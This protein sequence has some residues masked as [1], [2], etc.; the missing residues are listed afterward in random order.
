MLF[1]SFV[2]EDKGNF[3]KPFLTV[4]LEGHDQANKAQRSSSQSDEEKESKEGWGEV[5]KTKRKQRTREWRG[6]D[7]F[8]VFFFVLMMT[9]NVV[10][11]VCTGFYVF[12]TL[13]KKEGRKKR[14]EERGFLEDDVFT[15]G[16]KA[17]LL[18]RV[19]LRGELV[20][21]ILLD[22]VLLL[23]LGMRRF[24][25]VVGVGEVGLLDVNDVVVLDTPGDDEGDEG[26]GKE[27][28]DDDDDSDSSIDDTN[29]EEDEREPPVKVRNDESKECKA[30]DEHSDQRDESDPNQ[31]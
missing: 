18:D 12:S 15:L 17:V 31:S 2:Q 19:L 30:D 26:N 9:A 27:D 13:Y 14:E 10:S 20:N 28:G 29:V 22:A 5:G 6:P 21:G 1:L 25:V 11:D 7:S 23:L 24:I 4:P 16:G 8:C 3:L